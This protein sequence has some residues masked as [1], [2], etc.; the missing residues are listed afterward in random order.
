MGLM[1]AVG[2]SRP[3]RSKPREHVC[4]LLPESGQTGRRLGTSALCHKPT[5]QRSKKAA[6]FDHL[7]GELLEMQ[8]NVQTER[9]GGLEVDDQF[10]LG[11]LLDREVA[12]LS[13]LE[14]F[15]DVRGGASANVLDARSVGHQTASVQKHPILIN[16]RQAVRGREVNDPLSVT[17]GEWIDENQQRI[18][19]DPR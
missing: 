15:V 19:A 13:S 10:K 18:R 14:N 8:G 6:L 16:R 5:L 9:P 3:M 1:T 4:P 12:W 2:H 7:V 11:G 17:D